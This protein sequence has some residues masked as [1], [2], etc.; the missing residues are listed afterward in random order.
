MQGEGAYANK[1]PRSLL[2]AHLHSKLLDISDF[3]PLVGVQTKLSRGKL[4]ISQAQ[5]NSAPHPRAREKALDPDH[6]LP[7]GNFDGSCLQKSTLKLT[8]LRPSSKRRWCHRWKACELPFSCT[9]RFSN[10]SR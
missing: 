3:G 4:A 7:A 1:K 5:T 2:T 10:W 8:L 6:I 9:T